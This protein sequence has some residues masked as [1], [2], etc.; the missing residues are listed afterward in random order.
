MLTTDCLGG[1]RKVWL[2][3]GLGNLMLRIVCFTAIE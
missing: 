2:G 1:L 3:K